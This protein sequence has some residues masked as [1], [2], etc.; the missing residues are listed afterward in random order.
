M[1]ALFGYAVLLGVIPMLL[2]HALDPRIVAPTSATTATSGRLLDFVLAMTLWRLMQK[3][4]FVSS[5]YG[6]LQGL[7]AVIR[8]PW[9]SVINGLATLRAIALFTD[10]MREKRPWCGARPNTVSR[11]KAFW[12]SSAVSSARCSS[13]R[14]SWTKA[15]C[16][17]RSI[18]RRAA[19]AWAIRWCVWAW[20]SERDVIDAIA[21]QSGVASGVDNDLVPSADA[22]GR[23]PFEVAQD[24]WWLPLHVRGNI[25][26]LA[27]NPMP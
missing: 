26:D 21:D 10:A 18:K 20:S 2:W 13:N 15:T 6:P 23:L 8:P 22:L 19:N 12:A 4:Y 3:A 25:L 27:V 7:L 1:F 14:T 11:A 17:A 16:R 24:N 5:I 9:G